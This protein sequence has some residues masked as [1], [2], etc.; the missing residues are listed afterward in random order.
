MPRGHDG[1]VASDRARPTIPARLARRE[2][3]EQHC[4]RHCRHPRGLAGDGQLEPHPRDRPVVP[5]VILAQYLRI[6]LVVVG[7]TI[8]S[9]YSYFLFFVLLQ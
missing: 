8:A 3:A 4:A 5:D 1:Y 9:H 7:R 6:G 2:W